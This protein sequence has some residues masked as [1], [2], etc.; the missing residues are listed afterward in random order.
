[1][2]KGIQTDHQFELSTYCD[3]AACSEL[4][5]YRYGEDDACLLERHEHVLKV[6]PRILW[7]QWGEHAREILRQY[8]ESGDSVGGYRD[9]KFQGPHF[10]THYHGN[11]F[12]KPYDFAAKYRYSFRVIPDYDFGRLEE[13]FWIFNVL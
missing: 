13:P 12:L 8:N 2:R 7:P 5:H 9:Y 4:C 11:F 1:M 6:K 3:C 10:V